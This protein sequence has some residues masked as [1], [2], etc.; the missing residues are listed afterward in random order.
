[1]V[2]PPCVDLLKFWV[3]F[4]KYVSIKFASDKSVYRLLILHAYNCIVEIESRC[5]LSFPIVHIDCQNQI[6]FSRPQIRPL[7]VSLN[8][9]IYL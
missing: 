4:T 2:D 8:I 1:M 9:G 7:P 3:S 6:A 5:S